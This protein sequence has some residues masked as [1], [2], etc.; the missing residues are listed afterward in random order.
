[1]LVDALTLSEF[2]VVKESLFPNVI[3][4]LISFLTHLC[5]ATFNPIT[6]GILS[7]SQLRVGGGGV[8]PHPRKQSKENL[9]ENKFGTA[10]YWHKTRN[11]HNFR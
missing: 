11:V 4:S 2:A 6:Y 7:F 10:N 9:I 5:F 8:G 1:M 3:P